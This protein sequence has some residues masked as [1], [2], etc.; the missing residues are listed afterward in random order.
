MRDVLVIMG[1]LWVELVFDMHAGDAGSNELADGACHVQG[2]AEASA[3]IAEHG[4]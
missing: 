2:L 1:A 4:Q 3:S